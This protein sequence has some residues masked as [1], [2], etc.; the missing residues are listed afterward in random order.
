M[1]GGGC[2][3]DMRLSKRTQRKKCGQPWGYQHVG[4]IESAD[5]FQGGYSPGFPQLNKKDPR[6]LKP[7][8]SEPSTKPRRVLRT[9]R[10]A[11]VPP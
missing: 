1:F 11:N 4:F 6:C 10:P 2:R 5:V 7:K 3:G 8:K 9:P